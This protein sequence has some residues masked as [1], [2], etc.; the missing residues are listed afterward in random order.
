MSDDVCSGLKK[1][2]L[3]HEAT[4]IAIEGSRS[5]S[6]KRKASVDSFLPRL[7]E[8][9]RSSPISSH[10]VHNPFILAIAP[11]HVRAPEP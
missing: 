11:E 8:S 7:A 1:G 10:L 5:R 4:H 9:K 3:R 6:N 2:P